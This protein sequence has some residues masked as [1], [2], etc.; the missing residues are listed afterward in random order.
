PGT[1]DM[2]V[3][4]DVNGDNVG[5]NFSAGGTTYYITEMHR[6]EVY[7]QAFNTTD[8]AS[9]GTRDIGNFVVF[10]GLQPE[11]SSGA[12]FSVAYTAVDGGGSGRSAGLRRRVVSKGYEAIGVELA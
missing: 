5:V 10:N 8:P 11:G 1:Y 9:G 12:V 3:Y 4:A 2:V 7:Q 6:L